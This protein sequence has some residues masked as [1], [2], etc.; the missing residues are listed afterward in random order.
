MVNI[1]TAD[2]KVFVVVKLEGLEP[3]IRQML[4]LDTND[5]G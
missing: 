3:L 4:L 2:N 5:R 1:F